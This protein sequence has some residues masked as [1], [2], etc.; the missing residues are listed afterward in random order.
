MHEKNKNVNV[1][2][3][4]EHIL[5][6]HYFGVESALDHIREMPGVKSPDMQVAT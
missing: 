5:N 6:R 2:Y 3:L 1:W 4:D